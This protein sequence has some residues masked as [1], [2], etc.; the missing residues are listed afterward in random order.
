MGGVEDLVV[1]DLFCGSGAMGLEALSR[2]AA[3]VTFVDDDSGAIAAARSNFHALRLD[4]RT[5]SFVRAVLPGWVH[6]APPFD[7][8]FCDPPYAFD[9]WEELLSALRARLVVIESD[10]PLEP[11][12]GWRVARSR[13]YGGTLVTVVGA[14]AS[15][16]KGPRP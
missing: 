16:E 7:L 6:R 11:P 4:A 2:G 5:A 13:R 15:P 14:L 1:A 9:Q 8:V 3:A 10:R 12:G